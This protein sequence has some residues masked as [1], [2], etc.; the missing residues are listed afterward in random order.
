MSQMRDI[1]HPGGYGAPGLFVAASD[2]FRL[3]C[4]DSWDQGRE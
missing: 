3:H 4:S 2:E 1:G